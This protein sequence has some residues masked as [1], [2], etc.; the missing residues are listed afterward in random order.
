MTIELYQI[1]AFTS[2]PFAGNPAAVCFVQEP[3][4]A[5]WMQNVAAE[6]NLSETAF[7]WPLEDGYSLRWFTPAAEVNLCG[8]ATLASAHALYKTKRL[9]PDAQARFHTRSGLLTASWDHRWI[10]LDFPA[11]PAQ[12][13]E[14]PPALLAALG[15]KRAPLFTGFDEED[16]LVVVDGEAIVRE[17]EPDF[18]SLLAIKCRGVSVTSRADESDYDIV[19]RFF[20][21][22]V[23]IKE[24]PVTGSA[25]CCLGPY[26]AQELGKKTLVAYQASTRGGVLQVRPSGNRVILRGQAVTILAGQFLA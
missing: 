14:T 7:L 5:Q 12:P 10:E 1:D 25:H 9:A 8:H 17:L 18:E 23:G 26:W 16:Y 15:L 11:L 20:A 3:A 4:D 24:D 22:W 2:R 13:V 6:M 21:P 19:S